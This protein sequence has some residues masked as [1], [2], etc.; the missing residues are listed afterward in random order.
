MSTPF[1]LREFVRPRIPVT[2]EP[3]VPVDKGAAPVA[4][5]SY[6]EIVWGAESF[7]NF[8]LELGP[9]PAVRR[10]P[11]VVT[12]GPDD[13][14]IERIGR[15]VPEIKDREGNTLVEDTRVLNMFAGFYIKDFEEETEEVKTVGN[16][17]T[18]IPTITHVSLYLTWS[19]IGNFGEEL[20]E[21]TVVPI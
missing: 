8:S 12:R 17:T 19:D 9:Q 14:L 6:I 5:P 21:Q 16:V 3:N 20:L 11:T 15:A 10:P 2:S 7:L 13:E 1:G 4:P 18:I